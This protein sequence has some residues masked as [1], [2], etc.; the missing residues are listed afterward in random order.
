MFNT[1][2]Q[3]CSWLP[4]GTID[5]IK[6][7]FLN[8]LLLFAGKQNDGTFSCD[9]LYPDLQ[10]YRMH[11]FTILLYTAIHNLTVQANFN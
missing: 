1:D 10:P 9:C 11:L 5:K 8:K 3:I 2:N 7:I 4:I 6:P